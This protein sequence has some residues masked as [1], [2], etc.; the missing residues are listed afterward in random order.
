MTK[1]NIGQTIMR[2]RERQ[3]L[4][5]TGLT[6]KMLLNTGTSYSATQVKGIEE[7]DKSYS[8]DLLVEACRALGV[9]IILEEDNE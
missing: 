2:V 8:I 4:T 1:K 5:R 3:G 9:K 7:G 6:K